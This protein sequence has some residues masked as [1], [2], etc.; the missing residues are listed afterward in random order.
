MHSVT[1]NAVAGALSISEIEVSCG[2]YFGVTR[3]KKSFLYSNVNLVG[4]AGV[5]VANNFEIPWN[6]IVGFDCFIVNQELVS[7]CTLYVQNVNGVN[8]LCV[9]SPH[10]ATVTVVATVYYIK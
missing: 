2:V 6:K 3:Y 1:S 5:L 7:D 4:N 10:T 9:F 8:Q